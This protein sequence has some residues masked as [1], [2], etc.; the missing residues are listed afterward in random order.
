MFIVLDI[1][2]A[3]LT[4]ITGEMKTLLNLNGIHH[5]THQIVLYHH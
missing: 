1:L 4:F 5:F 3:I 2:L